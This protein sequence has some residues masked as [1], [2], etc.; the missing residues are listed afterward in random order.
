MRTGD[1]CVDALERS[2][3]GNEQREG[4]TLSEPPPNPSTDPAQWL[5][6]LYEANK[7]IL[8]SFAQGAAKGAPAGVTQ[9]PWSGFMAA[10]QQITA[11]QQAYVQQ[12]MKLWAGSAPAA[13]ATRDEDRRFAADAWRNDP[14]FEL[15]KRN[16]L[17]YSDFLFGVADSAAVDDRTKGQ[18]KFATRQF[19][20]AV[21]PANFLASNPEAMQLAIETGGKSL[22]DGM[23]LLAQ[24]LAK[25]R[26]SST[27]ETA[28]EVGRNIAVSPGAVVFENELVQIIQY[29]PL[30]QKVHERPLVIIP[31][32][33]NKYYI[34]DLQPENSLVRYAVGQ[35]QTVF[36]A[37][38]RGATAEI[39]HLTW[40]DYLERG[41]M[42]ALEVALDITGADKVNALGFCIGGTLLTSALQVLAA[43]G[44]EPAASVTLLTTMLD[45]S[46]TGE[47]GLLVSG[48]SVAKREQAIGKAGV[49]QGKE[50]AFVFSALRANDLVWPY[51]VS[52]YLKGKK[53][54]A[55]DL[56]F[57]NSDITDLPGPMFCWYLRNTYLENNLRKPG[58]TVQCG[59]PVDLSQ[60][61]IPA[62]I[63]ASREDHIVPWQTAYASVHLLGGPNTFVLGAS[64]HIA[65]VINPAAKN[66]RNYWSEGATG[67][68]AE[69]WL[70]TAGSVPGS[71]W[72]YWSA[73][74]AGHAGGEVAARAT[75]GNSQYEPIEPAPGR[76]VKVRAE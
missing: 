67:G 46:E 49:M 21:S 72:N 33:I 26:I 13:V 53:P 15:L 27:D 8:N 52:N 60:V 73:W 64:G 76:Y 74:L 25:G 12:M 19:V 18:L 61:R 71:W 43:S 65:G 4:D 50:L 37:S 44:A 20:D 69:N 2:V 28:F 6:N 62:F 42:K 59:V 36:L 9:D 5:A 1:S 17:A 63:Y 51:V 47:I 10:S 45:F 30:T 40:D 75:L 35:G 3:A 48:E 24:D 68:N 55:F 29:A 54:P 70:A 11:I 58:G 16:Y 38:W 31:P 41:V 66:K 32:C 39:A 34:L 14:R 57:W 56:L 22:I 7:S 23:G